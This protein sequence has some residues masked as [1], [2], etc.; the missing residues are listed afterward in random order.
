MFSSR[1]HS[2]TTKQTHHT[3]LLR[4]HY[5][6]LIGSLSSPYGPWTRHLRIPYSPGS[7]TT[8]PSA[9]VFC[10][11]PRMLNSSLLHLVQGRGASFSTPPSARHA[12]ETEGPRDHHARRIVTPVTRF[13][14]SK[15]CF[16]RVLSGLCGAILSPIREVRRAT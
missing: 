8:R 2:L 10:P 12:A 4:R 14:V 7:I 9:A 11:A 5:H 1:Q 3:S 13:R 15:R 6:K 16:D